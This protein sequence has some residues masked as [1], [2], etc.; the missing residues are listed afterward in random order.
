VIVR[1]RA[2]P[3]ASKKVRTPSRSCGLSVARR[4]G[5]A[6]W[7]PNDEKDE[8]RPL[9]RRTLGVAVIGAFHLAFVVDAGLVE[10]G[11]SAMARYES[12]GDAGA[13]EEVLEAA[14]RERWRRRAEP[15]VDLGASR[16]GELSLLLRGESELVAGLASAPDRVRESAMRD[17]ARLSALLTRFGDLGAPD[18]VRDGTREQLR[19]A[20]AA[21]DPSTELPREPMPEVGSA[22][23]PSG[24]QVPNLHD[25]LGHLLASMFVPARALVGLGRELNPD[26]AGARSGAGIFPEERAS[27]I[28]FT[29]YGMNPEESIWVSPEIL[30]PRALCASTL[31]VVG[32]G[33]G[34]ASFALAGDVAG[35]PTHL[36]LASRVRALEPDE[37]LV[38]FVGVE[39]DVEWPWEDLLG[40]PGT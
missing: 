39:N 19:I 34:P 28:E 2:A 11:V 14:W 15:T 25:W 16:R 31:V 3:P 5:Y 37:A 36:E 23:T 26:L 24:D 21:L 35:E 18:V 12:S 1:S 7:Q 33:G 9:P 30:L 38:S 6:T 10:R 27:G 29:C 20:V 8:L 13:L 32:V 22:M 17:V 40:D 4:D